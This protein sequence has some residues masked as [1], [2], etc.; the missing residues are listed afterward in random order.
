MSEDRICI[1]N[2]GRIPYVMRLRTDGSYTLVGEY[3]VQGLMEGEALDAPDF[4]LE[5]IV[6]K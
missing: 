2:G 1:F 6:L 4:K 3:W 5:E